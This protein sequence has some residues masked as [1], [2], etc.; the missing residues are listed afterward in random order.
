M[1]PAQLIDRCAASGVHLWRVG[2]DG[3]G[4]EIPADLSPVVV[5][6]LLSALSRA[7]PRVLPMLPVGE[8]VWSAEHGCRVWPAGLHGVTRDLYLHPGGGWRYRPPARD[9]DV[10]P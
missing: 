4:Y 8:G 1:T 9:G 2:P 7:K 3:I 6:R 5:D 10:R